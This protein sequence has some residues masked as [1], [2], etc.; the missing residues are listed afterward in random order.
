MPAN[1]TKKKEHSFFQKLFITFFVI[2]GLLC[3]I[4]LFVCLVNPF[5]DPTLFVYTSCLSLLFWP[6]YI[7]NIIVFFSLLFLRAGRFVMIPLL[8]LMLSV[9][10]VMKSFGFS[11]FEKKTEGEFK[12]MSYNVGNYMDIKKEKTKEEV[13]DNLVRIINEQNPDVI[14]LIESGYWNDKNAREFSQKIKCDYFYFNEE[15]VG[16][17]LFSKYPLEDIQQTSLFNNENKVGIMKLVNVGEKGSFLIEMVHLVSFSITKEEISFVND[18][19]NYVDGSDVY[20]KS[21]L[22]KLMMGFKKRTADTDFIL[23]HIKDDELPFV[24]CGDF[25]DTPIS[26][27]YHIIRSTGLHDAFI[28]K[29]KGIGET[30]CGNLP[31]LRIDYVWYNNKIDNQSFKIIKE[32]I[33]DHYPIVMTFNLIGDVVK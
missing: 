31:F 14:C 12:I 3:L 1:N 17:I 28:E 8:A 32:K 11:F 4:C 7:V 29:G 27:T 22:K 21:L 24:L 30:Y 15:L 25:N 23:S 2:I 20:G 26:Y 5:V 6:V 9:P 33:S 13:K 18:A 10:C 16:K 19:K